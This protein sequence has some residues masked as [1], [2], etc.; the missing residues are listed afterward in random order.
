MSEEERGRLQQ[1]MAAVVR[2]KRESQQRKE[3]TPAVRQNRRSS[4]REKR[5]LNSCRLASGLKSVAAAPC[6]AS[7]LLTTLCWTDRV[8]VR[9]SW[10]G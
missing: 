7:A 4:R 5:S 1:R 3:R 9:G 2:K 6:C 10:N 8:L